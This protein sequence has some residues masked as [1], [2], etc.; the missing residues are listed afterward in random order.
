MKKIISALL[1]LAMVLCLVACGNAATPSSSPAEPAA[2]EPQ[3]P[4]ESSSA[5]TEKPYAGQTLVVQVWGGTYEETF[6][7]Y[8][9]PMFEELTGATIE[10]VLG[11][12]PI[13]QLGAEGEN[14]S[15]DLIHGDAAEIVRGEEM[16]LF[17]VIDKSKLSNAADLYEKAFEYP[18]AIAANWGTYGIAY[19]TDLVEKAPTSWFDMWDPQYAGGK[20]GIMDLGMGGALEMADVVAR[21]QGYECADQENWDNLFAKL[22]ELKPNV[23]ILA[24]QH[25]DVEAMLEQGDV[26]MCVETNGR[27]INMMRSGLPVGFCMPEEGVPAMTSYIALTKHSHNLDLAYIMADI[28]ISPEVQKA[29]AENNYYAPSNS[30]AEVAED[31]RGFMPYGEDQV[32]LLVYIDAAAVEA[33]KPAFTERWNAIYK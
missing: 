3:A 15:V 2:S 5:G 27:A 19:R 18:E 20:V 12:T 10:Y 4:A 14:P 8:A 7:T 23:G 30:K 22:A 26:V 1:C 29:Y 13:A 28:L 21:T 16:D 25:A 17:A 33:V 24:S 11:S 32:D 6:K 9:A 31:L